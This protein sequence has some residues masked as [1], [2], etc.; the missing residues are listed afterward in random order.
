MKSSKASHLTLPATATGPIDVDE[1]PREQRVSGIERRFARQMLDVLG[2]PPIAL[3]L[4]NGE[5]VA[6]AGVTP[7]MRAHLRDRGA[8]YRLLINPDLHFGDLYSVG[9]IEVEGDLI[10]F[11]EIAYRASNA[12]MRRS[13]LVKLRSQLLN[14]PRANSLSDSRHNIHH[15]YDLGNDFYRLWLD[16][17]A[18]Q[19]TC[20]YYPEPD[21]TL[22]QAQIAKLDHIARKLMLKPGDRVVEAGCGWGGLARHFA[23]HYGVTVRAYNISQE[24]VAF[25]RERARAEGLDGRVEYVLDDYRNIEG[26]FDVFVSIG[27]LEHVG[28]SQYREL[29]DVIDRSLTA[30]GRGLIHSIGRNKPEKMNAWIERRIFP[31][32]YPPTLQEMMEIFSPNDLSVLDVENLRLHYARTLTHWLERFERHAPATEGM[33]DP[34]FVR[35]WRLYLAGSI[36][37]FKIGSLQLFQVLFARPRQNQ[38]PWSRAHLYR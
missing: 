26:K 23:K 36:A 6:P 2:N 32:A 25:A 19:Y 8:L 20:A 37:A 17:E 14:R 27:M 18:M 9:R 1:D 35:A 22:E 15:H 33:F 10:A 3:R 34:F 5:E 29:G 21:M 28:T 24:Q 7:T 12:A 11:L 4:W 13:R 16:T 38:L 30:G 31:G